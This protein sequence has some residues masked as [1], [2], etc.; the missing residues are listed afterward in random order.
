MFIVIYFGNFSYATHKIMVKTRQFYSNPDTGKWEMYH[1]LMMTNVDKSKVTTLV[2]GETQ[3]LEINDIDELT[4]ELL[5][6]FFKGKATSLWHIENP[7]YILL[8]VE[9]DLLN[10]ETV[11]YNRGYF[12]DRQQII[13]GDVI[14]ITGDA[15]K[16]AVQHLG[17]PGEII[18]TDED[19]KRAL[20]SLHAKY[21]YH[22]QSYL[23]NPLIDDVD[24]QHSDRTNEFECAVAFVRKEITL[25]EFW[26]LKNSIISFP[27]KQ[28][29]S[30][31]EFVQYELE[32]IETPSAFYLFS[33]NAKDLGMP[34]HKVLK[35]KVSTPDGQPVVIHGNVI[36]FEGKAKDLAKA[37]FFS[38]PMVAA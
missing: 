30:D 18:N 31:M 8:H 23:S 22:Y 36:R 37:Y 6:K 33:A 2:E 19:G 15:Y 32:Y 26:E 34:H 3:Y 16:I 21:K 14:K 25:Q 28:Y 20:K 38:I 35:T 27:A 7:G 12:N 11:P 1:P 5:D 13:I 29:Q 17:T 24:K 9:Q 10:F 4:D